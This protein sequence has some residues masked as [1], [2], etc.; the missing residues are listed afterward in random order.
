MASRQETAPR[1]TS[2]TILFVAAAFLVSAGT[3]VISPEAAAGV[4]NPA[5]VGRVI[6]ASVSAATG[7]EFTDG[8]SPPNVTVTI[9]AG[10]LT[11]DATLVV[12]AVAAK[13]ELAEG[14]VAASNSYRIQLK[15]RGKGR[16]ALTQPMKIA[17]AVDPAP[18]HPQVPEIATLEEETWL[19]LP[20]NFYRPAEAAVVALSKELRATYRAVHRTLQTASGEAVER[21]RGVFMYETFGNEGFFGDVLGLHTL[22]NDVAPAD[23]VNLGVQ[24]DITRVPQ[25]I[26]DVLLGDDFAAKQAA[27]GDPAVTRALIRAG[28][29][30]GVVGFYEDADSDVMTSA[31]ITC[32]LCHVNVEP[33]E[34]ELAEGESVPLPIG[35]PQFDGVPNNGL[36]AG[37]ILSLTPGVAFLD[38]AVPGLNLG[39]TLAGWGPGRF[40]VRALDVDLRP[41]GIEFVD[42]NP[43]E[44]GIDNPTT[45]PPIWNFLDLS[46]QDYLIGWDGLFKDDGVTNHALASI[47]EAVYDLIFHGNG[48]FG[49]PP[50]A[51]DGLEG[52]GT[53]P[54]ELSIVPPTEL[55]EALIDAENNRPGN[56][57]VPAEKL[58]DMQEFMRSIA[59]PAPAAFDE[60]LAEAGFELFHGE[61]NCWQC[62][63]SA[64]FTGTGLHVITEVP[65]AGGLAAGIKVP[66]LRGVSQTAPYFHDG[67]A[68]DLAAVV[69]RYAARGMDVPM[70]SGAEREAIVEYL[71][72]L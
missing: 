28:A 72:S 24:V 68:E 60:T 36:D 52:G 30:V 6:E 37:A 2:R 31:G 41:L 32:G 49:V 15:S 47:S 13:G 62:H 1:R 50:F 57:V 61:A 25:E 48:A 66:G 11:K 58:L 16:L 43:L 64:E 26:V 17:L 4:Q 29:V 34:F 45:Y 44:D 51:L 19:R 3:G 56:D 63:A 53:V 20:A 35:A 54:P 65:P 55:V 70:L 71:R 39:A 7:G 21:G 12:R 10:A 14:Q 27:L 9:P 8:T 33:N 40:D 22:L 42:N 46:E 38:T 18:V 5:G 23:A 59:S 67:S 69:D